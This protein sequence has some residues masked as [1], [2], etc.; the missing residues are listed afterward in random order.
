MY[1]LKKFGEKSFIW[2]NIEYICENI[3][4][5]MGIRSIDRDSRGMYL[6]QNRVNESFK[7][8]NKNVVLRIDEG[9]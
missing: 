5:L 3:C 1:L 6:T 2:M 7:T 9:F 8:T 4:R